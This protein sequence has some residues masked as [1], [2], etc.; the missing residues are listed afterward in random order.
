MNYFELKHIKDTTQLLPWRD[1][2]KSFS[3]GIFILSK[4]IHSDFPNLMID[5]SKNSDRIDFCYADI[6]EVLENG[7]TEEDAKRLFQIGWYIDDGILIDDN[8]F[9]LIL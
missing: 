6:T 1:R 7:L 8:Y 5:T 3:E 2:Q 9:K 4:Y